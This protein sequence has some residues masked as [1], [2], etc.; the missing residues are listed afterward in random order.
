MP[1]APKKAPLLALSQAGRCA[2]R[3]TSRSRAVP[4]RRCATSSPTRDRQPALDSVDSFSHDLPWTA[5]GPA[6]W[7]H[8]AGN[9]VVPS[10]WQVTP[11]LT[12]ILEEHRP[13]LDLADRIRDAHTGE[14]RR[15]SVDGLEERG[16]SLV[17]FKHALAASPSD[18]RQAAARSERMLPNKL[19]AAT[20]SSDSGAETRRA[21]KASTS[22]LSRRAPA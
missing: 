5:C 11:G 22:T 2:P 6:K 9:G 17:G 3:P 18:P 13:A 1:G 20:T 4:E 12:Q 19:E 16:C 15:R 10:H 14:V 8:A 21:H 7:S